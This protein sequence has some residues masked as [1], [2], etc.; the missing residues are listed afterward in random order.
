MAA[1]RGA[2]WAGA[3]PWSAAMRDLCRGLAGALLFSFALNF[4]MLAVPLYSLQIYDRAM[5]RPAWTS[6]PCCCSA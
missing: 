3:N 1:N 6:L 4:L 2:T 5:T